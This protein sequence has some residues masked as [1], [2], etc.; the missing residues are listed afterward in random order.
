MVGLGVKYIPEVHAAKLQFN[1][2]ESAAGEGQG[3]L[4]FLDKMSGNNKSKIQ[5][6]ETMRLLESD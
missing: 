5:K 3:A 6:S 1:F 2:N 4:G